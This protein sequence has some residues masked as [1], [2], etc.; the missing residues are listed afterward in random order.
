MFNV[1]NSL[2]AIAVARELNLDFA[3]IKKGLQRFFGS[4]APPGS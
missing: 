2:A 4:A 3:T 1:Y